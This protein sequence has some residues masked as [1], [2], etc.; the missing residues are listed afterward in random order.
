MA[1]LFV[2][3]DP[4]K[5]FCSVLFYFAVPYPHGRA[6]QRVLVPARAPLDGTTR[7]HRGIKAVVRAARGPDR[8]NPSGTGAYGVGR[9]PHHGNVSPGRLRVSTRRIRFT[10]IFGGV[11]RQDTHAHYRL[12]TTSDTHHIPAPLQ[13]P[14]TGHTH[15]PSTML[16]ARSLAAALLGLV[17]VASSTVAQQPAAAAASQLSRMTAPDV[18]LPD[19]WA[20][21][22]STCRSPLGMYRY[23]RA[24]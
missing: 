21:E 7:R 18:P 20:R 24:S 14:T 15:Y 4:I 19:D 17:Y 3:F 12:R 16:K 1:Y 13:L 9:T 10:L 22:V 8:G 6:D 5:F 11:S 2:H 23:Q